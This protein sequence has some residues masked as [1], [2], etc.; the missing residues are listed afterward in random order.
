M[1]RVVANIAERHEWLGA[2]ARHPARTVA[3][4]AVAACL[5]VHLN[6]RTGAAWPTERTIAAWTALHRRNVQRALAALL[7]AGLIAIEPGGPRRATRYSLLM[8]APERPYD[9]PGTEVMDAP[10][11]PQRTPLSVRSGRPCAASADAPERP[12]RT[13]Q[14]VQ[15]SERTRSGTR[16]GSFTEQA[17]R[18]R[19]SGSGCADAAPPPR[20][21]R[22][23][24]IV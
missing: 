18:T 17:P 20:A 15:N 1:T 16:K 6:Q 9:G 13:P 3:I 8:D 23:R 2:V 21:L 11:P 7:S 10:A 12:Q 22:G 4:L 24:L 19:A 14:S 5:M